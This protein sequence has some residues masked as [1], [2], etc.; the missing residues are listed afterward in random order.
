[1]VEVDNLVKHYGPI[2]AVNGVSFEVKKGEILGFL[3]PNGAGKST[4]MKMVTCFLTPTSG[5]ARVKG[6]DILKNPI[7]V[8]KQLGY[9]PEAAPL[10]DDMTVQAFLSFVGRVRGF[11]GSELQKC[12][13]RVY[14]TCQLHRVAHQP[15]HT[16]SKGFR[17]RVCF[18]QALIH[19]PEILILDEP[20]DGLDPN[21]KKTVRDL[22]ASMKDEKVII[23][24]T[25]IL[26]EVDA[27]CTRALIIS[28]G[29][30]K[31]D[32]RPADLKKKSSFHGSLTVSFKNSP[33][34]TLRQSLLK[35]EGVKNAELVD[36]SQGKGFRILPNEN[37]EIAIPVL[38]YLKDQNIETKEFRVEEGRLD[39]VF[40]N[41]TQ[42]KRA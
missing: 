32:G 25:H 20:T 42:P 18:A 4:T 31:I 8:Q 24:S 40:R 5:T 30:V 17:Q 12:V 9:L 28:E 1:M 29:E 37:Q 33:D 2:R 13:D 41:I 14:E 6:F 3:G 15:I 19:D 27:I 11:S 16:L 35:I 39:E 22:I 34:E 26:E 38:D 23:F 36:L 10:Y 7:E 21:Q